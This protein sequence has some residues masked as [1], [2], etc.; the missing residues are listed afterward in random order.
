LLSLIPEPDL[1]ILFD[2]PADV[3]YCRIQ[4]RETGNART[5]ENPELLARVREKYLWLADIT[6]NTVIIDGTAAEDKIEA[7]VWEH[8]VQSLS[9]GRTRPDSEA[10]LGKDKVGALATVWPGL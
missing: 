1:T 8:V 6:L 4:K 10:A 5:D 9:N 3:A 7:E 2:V